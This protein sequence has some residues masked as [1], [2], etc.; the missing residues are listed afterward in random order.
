MK[1]VRIR[2]EPY[3]PSTWRPIFHQERKAARA[4]TDIEDGFAVARRQLLKERGS[5]QPLARQQPDRQ[6]I[7][8]GQSGSPKGGREALIGCTLSFGYGHGSA[9]QTPVT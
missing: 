4:A 8:A 1:N 9:I 6:I 5:P 7:G 3:D 2:I